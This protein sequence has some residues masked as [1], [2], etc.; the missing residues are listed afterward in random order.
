MIKVRPI[1]R[2]LIFSKLG[3]FCHEGEGSDIY[4]LSTAIDA[5]RSVTLDEPLKE[6]YNE[7]YNAV[8]RYLNMQN[9]RMQKLK[10]YYDR[11]QTFDGRLTEMKV[12]ELF[13]GKLKNVPLVGNKMFKILEILVDK[14]EIRLMPI[15]REYLQAAKSEKQVIRVLSEENKDED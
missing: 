6:H 1:Q 5:L 3:Q 10:A 12:N 13:L 14:T 2:Q 15:Q 9:V 8:C 11:I 4:H 7:K